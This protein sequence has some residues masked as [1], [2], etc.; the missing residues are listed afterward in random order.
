MGAIS[1]DARRADDE[2]VEWVLLLRE[3]PDDP[4]LRARFDAWLAASPLNA[5]AW[6]DTAHAYDR[7]G[8]ARPAF[9]PPVRTAEDRPVL[10][11]GP[12]PRARPAGRRPRASGRRMPSPRAL[13]AAAVAACLALAA[14]PGVLLRVEADHLTGTA[15]V[16]DVALADGSAVSLAP[17]SAIA[18]TYAGNRRQVRLLKGEALFDVRHDPS[19]PFY[20]EA[21]GITTMVLGTAFDVRLD[22]GAA[23][24]RVVRGKVRVD[25][26]GAAPPVSEQLVAGDGV[27]VGFDGTVTRLGQPPEQVAAWR[28]GRIIVRDRPA[29]E[30]VDALRP[31]F[32]GIIVVRGESFG[33]QRVTG[34]YNAADPAEAL[35]G[36]AQAY[37]GRVTVVTPWLLVL[38]EVRAINNSPSRSDD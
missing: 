6:A 32:R 11:V 31:W 36:L 19:R 16:G 10:P 33:R 22:A 9:A 24:T 34:L 35:R 2:A 27:R 15:E 29:A 4:D 26:A 23:T 21:G 1:D 37:G 3:D 17:G 12:V 5:A 38:S 13:V 14:A 18:V 8:D 25:Y 30:V 28:D 7:A 20:V